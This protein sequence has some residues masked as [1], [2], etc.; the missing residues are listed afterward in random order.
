MPWLVKLHGHTPEI[1]NN[2]K[3]ET[4]RYHASYN[5]NRMFSLWKDWYSSVLKSLFPWLFTP[6]QAVLWSNKSV[7]HV[8]SI[9]VPGSSAV[10]F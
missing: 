2:D 8:P 5:S 1:E 4:S 9:G 7:S 6:S 3:E 10:I